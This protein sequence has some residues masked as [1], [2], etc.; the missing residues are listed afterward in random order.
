MPPPHRRVDC[1]DAHPDPEAGK[2]PRG[3]RRRGRLQQ[4][5]ILDGRRRAGDQDVRPGGRGGHRH[6]GAHERGALGGRGIHGGPGGPALRAHRTGRPQGDRRRR[7]A[8]LN[9]TRPTTRPRLL[10]REPGVRRGAVE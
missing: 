6:R 7:R 4:E 1:G 5:D 3:R 9:P 2:T 10:T 8:G